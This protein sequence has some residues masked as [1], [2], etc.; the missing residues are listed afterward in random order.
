M[1]SDTPRE[2]SLDTPI[3]DDAPLRRPRKPLSS[4]A[5]GQSVFIGLAVLCT[6]GALA[7]LGGAFYFGL[8]YGAP[9]E[10][11]VVVMAEPEEPAIVFPTL[12]GAPAGVGTRDWL[13][14]RGGE[15]IS[16]FSEAFAL[17]FEV[18][19]CDGAHQAQLARTTLLSSELSEEFPGE[20]F[21]AAKAREVCRVD[22]LINRDIAQSFD[23]LVVEF[24]YPV[25]ATQWGAGQRGVYCF[26][27]SSSRATFESSLLY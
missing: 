5:T 24:S 1:P 12:S 22:D 17:E 27:T 21:V 16:S 20:P 3:I 6:L 18:V 13:E 19:S 2:D 10:Q 25:D 26:V 8:H 23:D 14:L 15:C 11:P 4:T 9:D 7:L